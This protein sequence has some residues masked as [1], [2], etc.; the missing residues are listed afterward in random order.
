VRQGYLYLEGKESVLSEL[1]GK[2]T[3]DE[4]SERSNKL[5]KLEENK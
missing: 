2:Q 5:E 3:I 4:E 1:N